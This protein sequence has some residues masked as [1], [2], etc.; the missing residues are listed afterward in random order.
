VGDFLKFWWPSQNIWTLSEFIYDFRFFFYSIV[1]LSG[2]EPSSHWGCCPRLTLRPQSDIIGALSMLHMWQK[3]LHS[4]LCFAC[5]Y[6]STLRFQISVHW[7]G[8]RISISGYGR[9]LELYLTS[10][11]VSRKSLVFKVIFAVHFFILLRYHEFSSLIKN[12]NVL[13]YVLHSNTTWIRLQKTSKK[14]FVILKFCNCFIE[15]FFDFY[16]V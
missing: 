1:W 11:I 16:P 7:R 13:Q 10:S 5:C 9:E 15:Y 4:R 14:K 12:W 8:M 2:A 3:N 6:I